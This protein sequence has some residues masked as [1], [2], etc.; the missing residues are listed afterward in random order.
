MNLGLFF[1]AGAEMGYGLP[2]GGKFAI[3]LFRLDPSEEK[4]ALRAQLRTDV[5]KR[6]AYATRWLPD[7]FWEKNIHA[8]G[9]GEF[10]SLIESSIENKKDMLLER[11]KDFDSL[12]T[13]KF[14]S[15]GFSAQ[16]VETA[17]RRQFGRELGSEVYSQ[18]IRLNQLLGDHGDLFASRY[19]SA[20]LDVV[21]AAP[22]A[23]LLKRFAIAFL[24]LLVGSCGHDLISRLNSEIFTQA[25]DDLPIFDDVSGLFRVEMSKGGLD[26][27]DLLITERSVLGNGSNPSLIDMLTALARGALEALFDGILDYQALIDS[28]FR[29]LFSPRTEWAKFTKMVIFMRLARRYIISQM[30]EEQNLPQEGYYHD[31][32]RAE[33]FGISIKAIG[34]ANYNSL[35]EK[36]G[37]E[38]GFE[39]TKTYHLNGGVSDFY[40]P[41]TNDVFSYPTSDE[42]P[43]DQVHVP[44]I[45]TQSGI[46]PLTSVNMSRR[47]VELFD[48]YAECD[49]VAAVGFGFHCDDSHI[50]GLFRK[51]I[52]EHEKPLFW[53][54]TAQKTDDQLRNTLLERLRLPEAC[55]SLLY[56]LRVDRTTRQTGGSLWLDY[57][58]SAR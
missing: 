57:I 7:Q 43:N 47:Y 39:A 41:Y 5:N 50:N 21:R 40:N 58:N 3:E 49:A 35:L 55:R 15:A 6:S 14:S 11:L 42:V 30:P 28:H 54:E 10:T 22:D 1:G 32:A 29:Y 18:V 17:Y 45:L 44:F 52:E 33:E 20:I 53:V 24:Q 12:V 37:A 38:L 25:P 23:S 9:K 16:S 51:L 13:A 31:L 26:A 46:K 2:S 4:Q 27:I 56:P 19:Y 8:F 48:H 34:T 36:L